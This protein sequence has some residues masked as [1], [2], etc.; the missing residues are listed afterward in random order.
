MLKCVYI[1]LSLSFCEWVKVCVH[2]CVRSLQLEGQKKPTEPQWNHSTA[3][4]LSCWIQVTLWTV[5]AKPL[6]SNQNVFVFNEPILDTW[7]VDLSEW[8]FVMMSA[9]KPLHWDL[10]NAG[11][12]YYLGSVGEPFWQAVIISLEL[13]PFLCTDKDGGDGGRFGICVWGVFFL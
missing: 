4:G 13:E 9:V 6:A 7:D 2:V 5:S 10:S 12:L 3:K 1:A 11:W 8:K